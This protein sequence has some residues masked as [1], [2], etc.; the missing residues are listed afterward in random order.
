MSPAGRTVSRTTVVGV[1]AAAATVSGLVVGGIALADNASGPKAQVAAQPQAT[2][3]AKPTAAPA[4]GERGGLRHPG[5]PGESDRFGP[6]RFGPG[7]FGPGGLGLAGR[8]LHGEFVVAKPGGGYQTVASQRGS[9][10]SVSSTAVTVKS[11]DGYT[12]TY[13]VDAKTRVNALREGIGSIK[14]DQQVAVVATVSGTTSTAVQIV[15]LAD[16][17]MGKQWRHP[18]Q[19]QAPAPKSGTN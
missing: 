11:T 6:R 12:H 9:V 15:D 10:Q 19:K 17:G 16:R 7:G 4:P 5:L 2:P 13:V 1:A 18:G 8:A 14:K 3:T